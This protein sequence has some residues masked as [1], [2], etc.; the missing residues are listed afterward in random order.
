MDMPGLLRNLRFGSTKQNAFRSLYLASWPQIWGYEMDP[1]GLG[2]MKSISSFQ[3]EIT[4][5]QVFVPF[6]G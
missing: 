5:R 3:V 6:L 1:P 4:T 2:D